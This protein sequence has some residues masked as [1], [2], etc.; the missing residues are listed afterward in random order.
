MPFLSF[1]L[2]TLPILYSL[3][4]NNCMCP[5]YILSTIFPSGPRHNLSGGG[6]VVICFLSCSSFCTFNSVG[7]LYI[8]LVKLVFLRLKNVRMLNMTIEDQGHDG[9]WRHW[10]AGDSH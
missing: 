7:V 2:Y 4:L 3:C 1:F 8:N 5:L 9:P 6:G 10:Q